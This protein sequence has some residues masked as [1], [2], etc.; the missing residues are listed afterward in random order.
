[1]ITV[2]FVWHMAHVPTNAVLHSV[3]PLCYSP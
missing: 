1:M 2:N 3:S